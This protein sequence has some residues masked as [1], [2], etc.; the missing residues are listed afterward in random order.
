MR[1][2][3]IRAEG[4]RL[5][6]VEESL[7]LEHMALAGV[8]E[9]PNLTAAEETSGPVIAIRLNSGIDICFGNP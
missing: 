1:R 2:P 6:A 9:Q 5:I 7:E 4:K 8:V 3:K